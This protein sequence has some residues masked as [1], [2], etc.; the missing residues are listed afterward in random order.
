MIRSSFILRG[1]VALAAIGTCAAA[2]PAA[3]AATAPPAKVG[4]VLTVEGLGVLRLNQTAPEV[5][6]AL[7]KPTK[8]GRRTVNGTHI[9][10][11]RYP[12]Y[13][14][15]VTLLAN[16]GAKP[17]VGQI[18]VRSRQYRMVDTGLRV[19]AR[20]SAVEQAYPQGRCGATKPG[21]KSVICTDNGGDG[22]INFV[23]RNGKRVSS[24]FVND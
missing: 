19:G 9:Q 23:L 1:A 7:G 3:F 20:R 14:I 18:T 22:G 10:N 2:A 8:I 13:G 6:D 24:I 17:D 4:T 21:A 11:W 5:R 16:Q 15:T 12:R